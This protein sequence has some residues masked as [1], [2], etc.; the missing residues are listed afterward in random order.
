[1]AVQESRAL[2][3]QYVEDLQTDYG[4]QI[5]AATA[6]PLDT[7]LFAT[8]VAEQDQA[9]KMLTQWLQHKAKV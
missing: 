1:M 2:P 3:P 8:K 5:T 4:K 6:A 9:Q 7:N